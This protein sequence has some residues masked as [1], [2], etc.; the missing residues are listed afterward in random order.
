MKWMAIVCTLLVASISIS[1]T[2]PHFNITYE[3]GWQYGSGVKVGDILEA[4]YNEINSYLQTCPDKIKV[5][6][7]DEAEMDKVGKHV[8]AFSAWN[9]RTSTIVLRE[10]TIKDKKMLNIVARH[11]ICHLGLNNILANK[12][13]K[14]FAWIEEGICMVLSHEPFDDVKVSKFIVKNDFMNVQDIAKSVNS[15]EYNKTKNGY[16]QSYSLCKYMVER[17]GINTVINMLKC[18]EIDFERAF[19]QY[20]GMDFSVFYNEWRNHVTMMSMRPVS[21]SKSPYRGYVTI[22]DEEIADIPS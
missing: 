18:P 7:I 10:E 14:E 8:E 9:K 20:T 17:F 12:D 13:S 2:T 19:M 4:A 15:D 11:E 22:E 1:Q 6:I 16:L 21:D 3:D 5:V